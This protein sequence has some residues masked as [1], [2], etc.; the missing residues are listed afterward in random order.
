MDKGS[1]SPSRGSPA[2]AGGSPAERSNSASQLTADAARSVQFDDDA[3]RGQGYDGEDED[4]EEKEEVDVEYVRSTAEL[5]GEVEELSLQVS[6]MGNPR[7]VERN[8]V[9]ELDAN[10]DDDDDEDDQGVVQGE[11]PLLIPRATR[12]ADTPSANKVLARLGEE[13]RTRSEWMVMFAPVAMAQAKWPVLGPELTQPI[14]S[15]GI[16]QLVEDTVLLLKAIGYRCNSRPN[17]LILSGWS[18]VRASAGL[19]QWK[20]RLRAEFGLEKAPG[21][22]QTIMDRVTEFTQLGTDP[23]RVP[24]PKAPETKRPAKVERFRSTV[25]TP[26]FEDTH[27]LTP[28]KGKPRG[29][30]YDHLY[31][32]SEE[33]ELGDSLDDSAG[34]RGDREETVKAQIRR[35]SYDETEQ[36]AGQYLELRTHFLLDKVAEFEGKPYCSD[37]SLQWLKRFMYEVKDICMPQNSWCDPFSLS[38]GRAAKSWYRQLSTKMQQHWSLLSEAFLDYY[39]SQ[40]DQSVRTRYNSARR[41]E[42]EPIRDF[43]IRLNGYVRTAKI[44][45]EKRG[46]DATDHVEHFLLNCG[47]DGIMDLLYPLQLADIQRVEQ[48][49]NKKILGK[50]RKKQHDRLV[51]SRVGEGRRNDSPQCEI[52][53]DESLE[54]RVTLAEATADDLYRG[55][56]PHQPSRLTNSSDP[57]SSASAYGLSSNS[58][59]D[60]DHSWNYV[61]TGAVSDRL[62]GTAPRLPVVVTPEITAQLAEMI[63]T[64]ANAPTTEIAE[65]AEMTAVGGVPTTAESNAATRLSS[66]TLLQSASADPA[67]KANRVF[68]FVGKAHQ[69]EMW[70]VRTDGLECEYDEKNG[71][72]DPVK[73]RRAVASMATGTRRDAKRH[74]NTMKLSPGERM[75]WWSVQKFDRQVCMRALVLGAIDV[76]D[77]GKGKVLTSSRATVEVTLGWHVVYKFEVWI[78]PHHAVVDLILGTDFMMPAGV[79][80]DLYNSTARL[81]DDVEIPLI[82][83]R[84]ACFTEPTYGDRV[85]DGPAES[86]SIPA[87]RPRRKQL[88]EDTHAFWVSRT[89]DWIT[90]VAHSSRGKLTRVLLANVSGKPVRRPAHFPVILWAPH[91]ELPPGD[92]YVRLN[93]ANRVGQ[94]D[95]TEWSDDPEAGATCQPRLGVTFECPTNEF[96]LEDYAHELAILPDLTDSASTVLDYSGSNVVCSVHTP[97]Q[98]EKLVKALKAQEGIMNV[99]ENTLPPAAYGAIYSEITLTFAPVS[100][101]IL[102]RASFTAPWTRALIRTRLSNF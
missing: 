12:N 55:G 73:D 6:R 35:F 70:C 5:L 92:G 15:T 99:S 42:N 51:A 72:G 79:R 37:A 88:R 17:S 77:I 48:I 29:G 101:R 87:G 19:T 43:L 25:G 63:G 71:L 68:A 96:D 44:Q 27:M 76:R 24:M 61:D 52:R 102:V 50:K 64:S 30:R 45:Y 41:K 81:P 67:V 22:Q 56:E 85:S 49:I 100:S 65:T 97:N 13:M 16:N 54:R 40:F 10:A 58:G 89:R 32:T 39:C 57:F 75:G 84:S 8:L 28:K 34:L 83:T 47:D 26:Y 3:A 2:T 7:P 20:R 60:S 46:A 90:T 21:A 18:L 62:V 36:D 98:R 33:A 38:L 93:S 82:K 69:P 9:A 4:D 31:D 74:S 11:S 91:G 78:M 53:R 86:L 1:S 95:A 80:L 23:S 59:S 94:R 66:Y 14:N